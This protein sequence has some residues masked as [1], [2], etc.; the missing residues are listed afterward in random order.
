MNINSNKER[1][2]KREL[3]YQFKGALFERTILSPP[4]VSPVVTQIHL[5]ALDVFKDS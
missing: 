1:W 5:A 4:K 2:G 3:E